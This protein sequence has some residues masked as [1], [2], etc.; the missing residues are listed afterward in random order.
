MAFGEIANTSTSV[1][2]QKCNYVRRHGIAACLLMRQ[3]GSAHTVV[4][5]ETSKVFEYRHLLWYLGFK[6]AWNHSATNK[7]GCLAQGVGE[8]IKGTNRIE[9]IHKPEIPNDCWKDMTYICF[10]CSIHTEKR[11]LTTPKWPWV[12]ISSTALM[13]LGQTQPCYS[14]SRFSST[15]WF[16]TWTYISWASIWKTSNSWHLSNNLSLPR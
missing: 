8:C 9:F 2:L 4:D 10:V 3:H 7:L 6:D 11:N 5:M 12:A 14:S 16:L 13:M 15:V 1:L